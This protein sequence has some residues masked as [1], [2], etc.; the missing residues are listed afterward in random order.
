MKKKLLLAAAFLGISLVGC[1]DGQDG[2]MDFVLRGD[3]NYDGIVDNADVAYLDAF[4]FSD[5]E[6]PVCFSAGD[7]NHDG[8][9]NEEDSLYLDDYVNGDGPMPVD[10]FIF[11]CFDGVRIE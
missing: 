6:A 5:G 9:L 4:V 8:W 10:P 3:V 1:A 7:V 2:D 11:G